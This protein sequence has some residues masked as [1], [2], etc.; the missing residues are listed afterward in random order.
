MLEFAGLSAAAILVFGG[1]IAP[2]YS[3]MRNEPGESWKSCQSAP[4]REEETGNF[5]HS[6]ISS[7]IHFVVG[8][9]FFV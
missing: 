6:F 8:F 2:F 3:L 9:G 5:I 1:K 7:F 4:F